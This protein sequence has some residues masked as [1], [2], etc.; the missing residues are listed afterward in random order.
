MNAIR[1]EDLPDIAPRSDWAKELGVN[2]RTLQAA[3]KAGRLEATIIS[4]NVVLYSK[5]QIQKYLGL[6]EPKTNS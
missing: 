6:A 2:P 5:P 3:Q 4:R 1:F